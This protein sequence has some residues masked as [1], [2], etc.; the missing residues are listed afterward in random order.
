M[1]K[2]IPLGGMN[3]I[4]IEEVKKEATLLSS[5]SNEFIVKYYESF[6]DNFNLYI[7]M[8]YC[9][10]GDLCNLIDTLKA[11]GRLVKEDKIWSYFVQ[12]SFGIIFNVKEL[13]IYIQNKFF[14]ETLKL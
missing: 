2:Q 5:L 10:G 6:I 3:Q 11:K 9:E 14:I 8:E 7:V 12:I 1:L 13:H 4:E